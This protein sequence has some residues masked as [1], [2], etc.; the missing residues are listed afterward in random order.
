MIQIYIRE[1]IVYAQETGL[2]R[3]TD[4]PP[5]Q[6]FRHDQFELEASLNVITSCNHHNSLERWVLASAKILL[7]IERLVRK[8]GLSLG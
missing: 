5:T 1:F 8:V 4:L 2:N 6:N 3:S 7:A